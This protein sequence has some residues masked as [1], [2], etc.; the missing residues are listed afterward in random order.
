[1]TVSVFV[2]GAAAAAAAAIAV[3]ASYAMCLSAAAAPLT[4]NSR[5]RFVCQ[6]A[7]ASV[8]HLQHLQHVANV[9]Q[10][11]DNPGIQQC[12]A[13]PEGDLQKQC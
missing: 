11:A 6:A 10:P 9:V 1:M 13:R 12:C 5:A 8:Q 3:E 4:G 7:V 2:T